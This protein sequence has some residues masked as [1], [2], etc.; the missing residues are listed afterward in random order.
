MEA[1]TCETDE[2][3]TNTGSDSCVSGLEETAATSIVDK[4]AAM[5]AEDLKEENQSCS[6]CYWN[7]FK[8]SP[9]KC[10][11]GGSKI[12]GEDIPDA[13]MN[14]CEFYLGTNSSNSEIEVF[15]ENWLKSHHTCG[16]CS[17]YIQKLEFKDGCSLVHYECNDQA[18]EYY[19]KHVTQYTIGCKN[20]DYE[21]AKEE[22]NDSRDI[23]IKKPETV[24]DVPENVTESL[25]AVNASIN[26]VAFDYSTVDKETGAFLQEKARK[27]ISIKTKAMIEMAVELEEVHQRLANHYQGT[28]GAWCESIGITDRT[29]RNYLTG[30]E[31][32]RKNFP[33]IE[34]A[35]NIQTS[36]LFAA[37]K[38][39][40]PAELSEKVASGD[41]TT[42]K[43]YVELEKRLKEAEGFK[44]V[45]TAQNR[46][47]LRDYEAGQT[48]LG[49]LQQRLDQAKRN[50]DPEKVKELG[51]RISG[52]QQEISD[53]QQQIGKLNVQLQE[54]KKQLHDKPIEVPAVKVVE[55]EVVP[56]DV[57]IAIY[58]K[59]NHL[60]N[61]ILDLTEKEISVYSNQAA[62]SYNYE[63]IHNRIERAITILESIDS[64]AYEAF[65]LFDP[66][67]TVYTEGSCGMCRFADMDELPLE[68][69]DEGNTWCT[70]DK[71]AV[72]L[73]HNCGR[74]ESYVGGGKG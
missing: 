1:S 41:I 30:L 47:L 9:S 37:S 18:S 16:K 17:Y 24:N 55:K 27:I 10:F 49:N 31:W 71:E 68:Q 21:G 38:P 4:L 56:E 3:R 13:E 44:K 23:D 58:N 59:I 48:K 11:G 63:A 64:A 20:A 54:T 32:V 14:I 22:M 19:E 57:S 15:K 60:Y 46:S 50:G 7:M 29:A 42:H 2:S 67:P 72:A 73:D 25:E 8:S 53:Y 74:F 39:S 45:L 69:L 40:A 28:F 51:Q 70:L 66:A 36:L 62:K 61:E 35:K 65:H 12:Y 34:D 43:Q 33:N 26:I 6:N 5:T 52:Y